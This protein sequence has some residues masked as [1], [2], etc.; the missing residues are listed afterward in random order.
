MIAPSEYYG[1][2]RIVQSRMET[3]L[4]RLRLSTWLCTAKLVLYSPMV[5]ILASISTI[6][7]LLS[8]IRHSIFASWHPTWKG[9]DLLLS[10]HWQDW[11]CIWLGLF[12]LVILSSCNKVVSRHVAS[13]HPEA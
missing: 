4:E 8:L 10:W 5:G 2:V 1:A 6:T 12:I 7:T 13:R 3:K 9:A 11:L